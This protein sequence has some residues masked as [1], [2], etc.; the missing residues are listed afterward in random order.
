MPAISM[1][2]VHNLGTAEAV[3][4]LTSFLDEVRRDHGDK[5]S[6]VRGGWEGNTLQFSF[7]TYGMAIQ[8]MLTVEDAA[9]KIAGKI[10]LAALLFRGQVEK[11]IREELLKLLS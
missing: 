8:G 11:T 7:T 2:V 6:D 9:V 3:G 4:R 5:V 10:P 1:S